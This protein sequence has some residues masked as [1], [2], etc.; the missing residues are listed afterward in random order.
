MKQMKLIMNKK[1][2][3]YNIKQNLLLD[4]S[5]NRLLCL[6]LSVLYWFTT[7]LMSYTVDINW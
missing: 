2:D 5:D 3:F 4:N 6:T 1:G 7:C